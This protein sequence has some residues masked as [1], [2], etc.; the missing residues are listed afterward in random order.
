MQP[1]W[2]GCEDLAA[3]LG[4]AKRM[5][6]LGR[7]RAIARYR[8]PAVVEHPHDGAELAVRAVAPAEDRAGRRER[9]L[10]AIL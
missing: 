10:A 1:L 3:R 9:D 7:Q 6:E 2:R 5:F 8:R 4:D